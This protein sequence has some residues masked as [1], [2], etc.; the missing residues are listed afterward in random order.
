MTKKRFVK[1]MMGLGYSRNVANSISFM[2][3]IR[4]KHGYYNA[5]NFNELYMFYAKDKIYNWGGM[6]SV[7]C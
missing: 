1:L 3:G 2:A 6:Y 5:P 4:G 7:T